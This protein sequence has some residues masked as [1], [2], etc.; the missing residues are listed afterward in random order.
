LKRRAACQ[1]FRP[2]VTQL[3]D[4]KGKRKG[5]GRK[6]TS[7]FTADWK[8]IPP[9][10]L[11]NI[12]HLSREKKRVGGRDHSSISSS[13][14]A[15]LPLTSGAERKRSLRK[16]KG[17]ERRVL[18]R[19]WGADRSWRMFAEKKRKRGEGS[20]MMRSQTVEEKG[21]GEGG[22]RL[23]LT[24]CPRYRC[25]AVG[26]PARKGGKG[27]ERPRIIL[28]LVSILCDP[29]ATRGKGKGKK[30]GEKGAPR[31]CSR[32]KRGKEG[33]AFLS[34]LSR[35]GRRTKGK[36]TGLAGENRRSLEEENLLL[37]GKGSFLDHFSMKGRGRGDSASSCWGIGGRGFNLSK[38]SSFL[39][40]EENV[41]FPGEKGNR[42]SLE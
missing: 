2:R 22:R 40:R 7:A 39:S 29:K 38:K 9:T 19:C 3:D 33:A 35:G 17:K 41:S 34:R 28:W 27:G 23:S 20:A 13:E 10:W 21:E 32:R 42:P 16:G 11:T 24:V 36:N 12:R 6:K 31:R 8:G 4:H 14:Q 25:Y 5:G 15:R 30:G 26:N 18:P 1:I 37:R